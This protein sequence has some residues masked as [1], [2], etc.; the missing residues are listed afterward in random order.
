[1]RLLD[2]TEQLVTKFSKQHQSYYNSYDSHQEFEALT[3]L[4]KSRF[5]V[6]DMLKLNMFFYANQFK[7]NKKDAPIIYINGKEIT[8]D[9]FSIIATCEDD[10]PCQKRLNYQIRSFLGRDT[11][12]NYY[13]NYTVLPKQ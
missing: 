6:G 10:K 9:P 8:S 7:H 1:M 5:K 11:V 4:N 13:V 12:I 2:I 3:T